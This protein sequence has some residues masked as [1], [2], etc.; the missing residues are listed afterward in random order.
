M[1]YFVSIILVFYIITC[2]IAFGRRI[3]VAT[4]L[5]IEDNKSNNNELMQFLPQMMMRK[6]DGIILKNNNK[7]KHGESVYKG[8]RRFNN[9]N[10]GQKS[11]PL[12]IIKKAAP[13]EQ[14]LVYKDGKISDPNRVVGHYCYDEVV[15]KCET[16]YGLHFCW[17]ETEKICSL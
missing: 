3:E 11:K 7:D 14:Q 2:E 17:D 6:A 15:H 4:K 12:I 9:N 13:N 1:H 8:A 5:S 10:N 16:T